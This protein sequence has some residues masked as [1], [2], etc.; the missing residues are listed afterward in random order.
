MTRCCSGVSDSIKSAPLGGTM[1]LCKISVV[2]KKARY[3]FSSRGTGLNLSLVL[4]E[5]D[6]DQVGLFVGCGNLEER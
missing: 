3:E 2:L 1:E 5:C 4:W 6:C